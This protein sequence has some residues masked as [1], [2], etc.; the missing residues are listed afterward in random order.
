MIAITNQYTGFIESDATHSLY[1]TRL[2]CY[3]AADVLVDTVKA[4]DVNTQ[5]I[6]PTL[7]KLMKYKT[8]MFRR[9]DP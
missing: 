5:T 9:F 6:I 2:I 1:Y 8:I 7:S 3:T 4:L